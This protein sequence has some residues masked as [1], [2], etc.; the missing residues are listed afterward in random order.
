MKN[1]G[2][3]NIQNKIL[4]IEDIN[5][6]LKSYNNGILILE[7]NDK[8]ER[9]FAKFLLD[10][11]EGIENILVDYYGNIINDVAFNRM[12]GSLDEEQKKYLIELRN[13]EDKEIF[14]SNVDGE[15]LE[16]LISLSLNEILFSSFYLENQITIWGN[17]NGKFVFFLNEG[18]NFE[19]IQEIA[20]KNNLMID[21]LREA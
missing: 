18:L 9:N 2:L 10:M 5:E 11:A 6:G 12:I 17:Y 14:Y 19:K 4:Y 8:G 20:K 16:I 15:F 21:D 13:K 3:N 1:L 7:I